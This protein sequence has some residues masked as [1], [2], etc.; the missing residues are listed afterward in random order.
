MPY[1]K[2]QETDTLTLPSSTPEET[3]TV[4]MKRR[5][6]YG[7]QLAAQSAM[8]KIDSA[9]G[10]ISEMEWGA[11]IRSLTVALIVSWTLTDANDHPLPIAAFS[12]DRLSAEDGQFLSTEAAKRAAL[13]GVAQERPFEKPSSSS[14][15]TDTEPATP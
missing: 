5:A 4:T 14:S 15:S 7:D 2:P 10:T 6:N 13:R 11:Y 9:Q 3:Y 12:L 1:L 8:L